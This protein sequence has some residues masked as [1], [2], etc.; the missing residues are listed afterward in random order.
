M[1]ELVV[2]L[3][4]YF[5]YPILTLLLFALFGYVIMSWLFMFNVLSPYG[6]VARQIYSMLESVFEGR[7]AEN[8]CGF[9]GGRT[10]VGDALGFQQSLYLAVFTE[11]SVQSDE[12]GIE[13]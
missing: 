7:L 9:L 11:F 10:G 12:G 2:A 5:V 1:H 4:Q 3:Y 6:Q 8:H 13:F